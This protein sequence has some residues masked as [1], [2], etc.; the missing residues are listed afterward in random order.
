MLLL[1]LKKCSNG[2]NHSSS[3]PHR[4]I[5]N[6]H[7]AKF[8]IPPMGGIPPT[9]PCYL[10]NLVIR[11]PPHPPN[12][13]YCCLSILYPKVTRTLYYEV[14]FLSL[15]ECPV[16]LELETSDPVTMP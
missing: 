6:S 15:V 1:A 3:D 4:Q 11:G 16:G 5:K 10:E 14:E 7:P 2:Q 12:A 8:P 13:N 9:D